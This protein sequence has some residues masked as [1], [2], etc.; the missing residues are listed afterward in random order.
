MVYISHH[1]CFHWTRAIVSWKES[2][3]M[4][5]CAKTLVIRD[6]LKRN[7]LVV[8]DFSVWGY[9]GVK[10]LNHPDTN[11]FDTS[12]KHN[13]VYIIMEPYCKVVQVTCDNVFVSILTVLT[14]FLVLQVYSCELEGGFTLPFLGY[15]IHPGVFPV[16]SSSISPLVKL[17]SYYV[18]YM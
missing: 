8:R 1:F 2:N 15:S 4:W 7:S 3:I 16:N 14:I 5:R 12:V 18:E 9:L 17:W 13:T 11:E 6:F 10:K